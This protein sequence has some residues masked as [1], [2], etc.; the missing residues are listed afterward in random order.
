M[1]AIASRWPVVVGDPTLDRLIAELRNACA[2]CL[3]IYPNVFS[4]AMTIDGT[5]EVDVFD[6]SVMDAGDWLERQALIEAALDA[7]LED[8]RFQLAGICLNVAH[9]A[10]PEDDETPVLVFKILRRTRVPIH[11]RMRYRT[12]GGAIRFF[13]PQLVGYEASIRVN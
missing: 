3:R 13:E 9:A 5:G 12:A 8:G 4:I 1:M 7:G 2:A 6:T 11:V 10:I